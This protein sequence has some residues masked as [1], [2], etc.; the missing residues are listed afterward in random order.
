MKMR[1]YRHGVT[2]F[3]AVALMAGLVLGL[4]APGRGLAA[5]TTTATS[6]TTTTTLACATAA[7][8]DSIRCLEDQLTAMMV[9]RA[10]GFRR[11]RFQGLIANTIAR[12]KAHTTKAQGKSGRAARSWL[13][14]AIR[15]VITLNAR[16]HSLTGKRSVD[17]ETAQM[18]SAQANQIRSQL[19]ALRSLTPG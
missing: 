8:Y 10:A 19:T 7:T 18:I 1:T 15:D 4:G 5:T 16:L 9:E 2:R 13:K 6:S 14:S 17:R 12:L 11:A 3:A